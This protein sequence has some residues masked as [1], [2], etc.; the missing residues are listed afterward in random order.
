MILPTKLTNR[1]R[2]KKGPTILGRPIVTAGAV[3]LGTHEISGFER[4]G[5]TK[6]WSKV[7]DTCGP[8]LIFD[9]ILFIAN[10]FDKLMALDAAS[11]ETLWFRRASGGQ[12][13]R[14][15]LLVFEDEAVLIVDPSTGSEVDR[16]A[17]PYHLAVSDIGNDTLLCRVRE[18]EG[19]AAAYDLAERKLRWKRPLLEETLNLF[20]APG[21]AMALRA[22]SKTFL[23]TKSGVGIFGCSMEDG[24]ILWHQRVFVSH[25]VPVTFN[26]R[27]YGLTT[28]LV[29]TLN[30]YARFICFD[31]ITGE[32]IYE[33]E[34]KEFLAY[35][36]S[37]PTVY[38]DH[39]YFGSDGGFV[40]AFRLADGELEWCHRTTGQTW[41]PTV[42]QDRI[43]VTSDDGY[44]LVFEGKRS[45]SAKR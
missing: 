39:V 35:R 7:H 8:F 16:M 23:L 4:D 1:V 44:L 33:T 9:H 11:G 42:F 3:F 20:H 34:H 36:P 15:Q 27:V 19:T 10:G 5:L 37:R 26:G 14:N 22:G 17:L 41:Q 30:D 13:W 31:E 18:N 25:D 12:T 24:R 38:G 29:P 28:G 40:F 45:L 32:K 43:Y 6:I 2:V 21:N